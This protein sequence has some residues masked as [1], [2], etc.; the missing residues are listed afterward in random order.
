M[1]PPRWLLRSETKPASR[2]GYEGWRGEPLWRID[3]RAA[4]STLISMIRAQTGFDLAV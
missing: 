2:S 3:W 4:D 1:R